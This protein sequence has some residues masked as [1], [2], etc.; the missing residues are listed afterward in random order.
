VIEKRRLKNS[1]VSGKEM[2]SMVT[3]RRYIEIPVL[4]GVIFFLVSCAEV[5][6]KPLSYLDTAEHHTYTG[7]VLL[8]QG[9]YRD[10]EREFTMAIQLNPEFSKAYAGSGLVQAYEGEFNAAFNLMKKAEKYAEK[11]DEK[12]Y[13]HIG[14]IRLLTMSKKRQNWLHM[15]HEQFENAV[16]LDPKASA[17]YYFMEFEESAGAFAKVLDLNDEYLEEANNE[18]RLLQKIQRL[19]PVSRT[20]K[21]IALV[22]SVTRADTAALFIEE[23]KIDELFERH[24]PGMFDNVKVPAIDIED[25][26]FRGYIEDVLKLGIRGLE[27]YPD[28]AFHPDDLVTRAVLATMVADI[29]IKITGNEDLDK[30]FTGVVSPF[31]D[32]KNDHPSFTSVMMVTARGIMQARDL[33][34]GEFSPLGAISGVDALSVVR[35]LQN[36]LRYF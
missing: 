15:A 24:N 4:I 3:Y 28:K 6:R 11:K 33:T 20:G 36:E 5:E 13:V 10:A 7:I 18:W 21:R 16:K 22:E 31:P 32:L 8:H 23:L 35:R 34:T 9:K 19:T 17:A 26:I 25:H 27:V 14:N 29:I 2:N 1:P 12:V 30:K